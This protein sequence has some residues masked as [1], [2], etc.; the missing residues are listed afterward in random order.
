MTDYFCNTTSFRLF[1][2]DRRGNFPDDV[3]V[4]CSC[5]PNLYE[6]C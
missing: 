5:D 6:K 1:I 3:Q 2:N 4:V